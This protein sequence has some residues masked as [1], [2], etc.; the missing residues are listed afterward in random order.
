MTKNELISVA[1]KC[2]DISKAKTGKILDCFM[3]TI[4]ESL[5][6]GEKVTLIGFGTFSVSKRVA[7][8]GIN[9]RTKEALRIEARNAPVFKAGK[10]LKEMV[11]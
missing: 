4:A 3:N 1:S 6:K 10:K 7:R 2:S 8:N 9:P 11:N 5:Q